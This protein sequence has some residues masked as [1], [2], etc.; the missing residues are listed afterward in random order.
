VGQPQSG[1]WAHAYRNDAGQVVYAENV[2]GS[3]N[4]TSISFPDGTAQST[5]GPKF[6]FADSFAAGSSTAGI[7]EAINSLPN[8]GTVVLPLGTV[9][10][11]AA[12]VLA[13]NIVLM[14]HGIGGTTIQNSTT[15]LFTISGTIS[16]AILENFSA[17]SNVGGGHI[18][19]FNNQSVTQCEIRAVSLV[20]QNTGK[21]VLT[22]AGASGGFFGNWLHE[23]AF[24]YVGSNT[25]P[26]IY[27]S[28]PAVNNV[29]IENF[30]STGASTS[31]SY[32]IWVEQTATSAGVVVEIRKGTFEIPGG[33]AVNLLTLVQSGISFCG[34][35][36]L[37]T[38][39][40][41]PM[42]HVAKSTFSGAA[43]SAVISLDHIN[44]T[45]GTASFPDVYFEGD[46]AGQGTFA[47]NYSKVNYLKGGVSGAGN[48][49]VLIGTNAVHRV[50]VT[51]TEL[52][53]PGFFTSFAPSQ[54]TLTGA[55]P[56]VGA[57]QVGLGTTTATSATA[58]AN[59]AVP[60][61]VAGYL[62]VNIGGTNFKIP[63][64]AA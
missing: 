43:P 38:T 58:G 60:A 51:A 41:N 36:D 42:F 7:Q 40:N 18:L 45:V 63:Y 3:V 22:S 61:Q 56:T 35:Y 10:T 30:R 14:G 55:P 52:D 62:V 6:A 39:P 1:R 20:Q 23:F 17:I 5:A 57:G 54:F 37:V 8:G 13:S 50:N 11:T 9:T 59:G 15:D 4:L 24:S 32:A 16:G 53:T 19:N 2:D 34:I 48:D 25:V 33:G 49:I 12:I 27:I 31:T 46:V 64:F 21:S 29:V 44:S 26:A 47:L 28:N